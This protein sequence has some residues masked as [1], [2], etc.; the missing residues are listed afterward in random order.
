MGGGAS[1][2]CLATQGLLGHPSEALVA[3]HIDATSTAVDVGQVVCAL[4]KFLG[5]FPALS[6]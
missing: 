1:P 5:I 3:V 6:F 2:R 4:R